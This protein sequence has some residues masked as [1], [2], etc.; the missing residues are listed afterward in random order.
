MITLIGLFHLFSNN[1]IAYT[2]DKVEL[3]TLN[4]ESKY[5]KR[6]SSKDIKIVKID[7]IKIA[8]LICFELRFSNLWQQ[9]KGCDIVLVPAMWGKPRK[10]NFID[11]TKALAIT[12]QCFVLASD[13]ANEDMA[14]SSAVITPFGVDYR[15][16][17]SS[18]I[19]KDIDLQDIKK[20]RR[21]LNIGIK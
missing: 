11:L 2:Q 19:Q 12:N 7:N 4:D 16:D 17:R 6:G 3:F 9:I 20:V 18:K 13:S 14:K 8:V 15:D 5:F 1:K 10:D 21:Y